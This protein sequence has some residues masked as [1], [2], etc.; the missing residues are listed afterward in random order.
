MVDLVGYDRAHHC[1]PVDH[2]RKVRE[3][4]RQLDSR[5]AVLAKLVRRTQQLGH[6]LDEREA[7]A[8]NHVFGNRLTVELLQLRLGIEKVDLR[9]TPVHIE[10]DDVAG[11][12][13]KVRARGGLGRLGGAE[14]VVPKH[15]LKGDTAKRDPP[16]EQEV[17]PR[18]CSHL[19]VVFGHT[20]NPW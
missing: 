8:S 1:N 14:Q 7:L 10:D 13:R 19:P 5:G 4:L 16:S 3:Q 15:A 11:A 9:R 18:P 6:S 12:R 17:A 2:L 20:I